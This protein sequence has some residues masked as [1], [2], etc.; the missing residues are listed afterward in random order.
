MQLF[1]HARRV[2]QD[3]APGKAAEVEHALIRH[4]F[5]PVV[6]QL[7]LAGGGFAAVKPEEFGDRGPGQILRLGEAA[8]DE[9]LAD[10]RPLGGRKADLGGG[11]VEARVMRLKLR[12]RVPRRGGDRAAAQRRP[13]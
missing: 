1:A 9:S 7:A 12:H 6:A 10:D 3:V 11:R 2:A 4:Q 8:G 5:A 13:L